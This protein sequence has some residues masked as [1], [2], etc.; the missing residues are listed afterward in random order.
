MR[1]VANIPDHG[2]W[3]EP[4]WTRKFNRSELAWLCDQ[5]HQRMQRLQIQNRELRERLNRLE[6][7]S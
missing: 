6:A 4:I 5:Q 7:T 3:T 2:D 1:E